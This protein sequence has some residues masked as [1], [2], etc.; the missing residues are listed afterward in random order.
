MK[1]TGTAVAKCQSGPHTDPCKQFCQINTT[2]SSM[3]C[4]RQIPESKD[5]YF[6]QNSFFH[7]FSKLFSFHREQLTSNVVSCPTSIL[8]WE[9]EFKM[10]LKLI[11]H[12]NACAVIH[13]TKTKNRAETSTRGP[14][15]RVI[16]EIVLKYEILN[17]KKYKRC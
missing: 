16:I 5:S 7:E 11:L 10:R 17:Q 4:N 8:L 13:D 1:P 6:F 9:A 2:V 12:N 3:S 15:A 14:T